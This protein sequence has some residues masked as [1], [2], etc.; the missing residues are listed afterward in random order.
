MTPAL[1]V[2]PASEPRHAGN[3][4]EMKEYVCNENNQDPTHLNAIT[5]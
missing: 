5:Q 4:M 2:N 3:C 1:T